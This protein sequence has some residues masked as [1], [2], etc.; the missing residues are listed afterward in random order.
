MSYQKPSSFGPF[1]FS[2]ARHFLSL[3]WYKKPC[4]ARKEEISS[5]GNRTVECGELCDFEGGLHRVKWQPGED[6]WRRIS[7]YRDLVT[8]WVRTTTV[9]Q[10]CQDCQRQ[11]GS[12]GLS[13]IRF[14]WRIRLSDKTASVKTPRR[15]WQRNLTAN[16][17]TGEQYIKRVTDTTQKRKTG[18][19]FIPFI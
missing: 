9:A 5:Q 16:Y 15:N 13:L 3:I 14:S 7:T 12:A 19:P 1:F 8:A 17:F 10:R 2:S 4:Y 6:L 11:G 18:L